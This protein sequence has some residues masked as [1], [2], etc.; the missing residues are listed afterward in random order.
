MAMMKRFAQLGMLASAAKMVQQR[1]SKRPAAGAGA[2]TAT[3]SSGT[4][5]QSAARKLRS[6]VR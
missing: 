6:R 3:G 2:S 5:W 1:L 4:S